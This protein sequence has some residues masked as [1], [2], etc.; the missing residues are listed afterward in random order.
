MFGKKD[1]SYNLIKDLVD[2]RH[3]PNWRKLQKELTKKAF[4]KEN[5]RINEKDISYGRIHGTTYVLEGHNPNK[6]VLLVHGITGSRHC[7]AILARRL[8][9]YGYFCLSIDLPSHHLNLR[10]LTVGEISESVMASINLLKK[11]YGMKRVGVIGHSLGAVGGLLSV[12]SYNSEMESNLYKIWNEIIKLVQDLAV[13]LKKGDG[14]GY[15]TQ[16][17]EKRYDELKQIIL[18]SLKR[19]VSNN[20]IADCYVFLAMPKDSKGA[21]PGL[22]ILNKLSEKN[23]RRVIKYALHKP[24]MKA[25]YK[26]GADKI[27]KDESSDEEYSKWQ[28]FKTKDAKEFINYLLN[29]KE[30]VDFLEFLEDIT[31]F[32]H[33]K[34]KISFFEYYQEKYLKKVP[35]LF[36]YGTKDL[37]LKPFMP[38]QQERLEKVYRSCGNAI[39]RKGSFSHII[40][41]DPN[42]QRGFL[43]L[44]NTPV[45]EH[46]MRFLDKHIGFY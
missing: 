36:I 22:K 9:L 46:I 39:V 11:N 23:V 8:A 21:V 5:I 24:Q 30:P 28:L 4:S 31:K 33:K 10:R 18:K 37:F 26:E 40:M 16:Q 14:I 15:Y 25:F 41:D 20:L 13:T 12:A 34:D 44:D 38:F 3:P 27:V 43:S 7:M 2:K 19:T 32:K 42:Q 35:K 45:T 6:A 29:M 17:I 1:T